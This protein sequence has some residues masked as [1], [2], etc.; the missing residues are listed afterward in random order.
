MPGEDYQSWST[1]A[2]NNGNADSA[3]NWLEGQPRASVNNSSRSQMAAHAKNRNLLNGSIVTTGSPNAQ[4]F[5]SGVAYTAMPP[6]LVAKL[7]IGPSL[8]NTGSAT[9]NMDGLGDILIK[10]DQG[11][12]LAGNELIAGGYT[13]FLYNGTNW[14]LLYSY[15]F[16]FNMVTGGGGLIVGTQVF[17]TPGS[18]VYTPTPTMECC[19]IE[20]IGGGGAGGGTNGDSN[21]FSSGGGGGSGGYSRATATASAIGSSQVVTVGAGGT[22]ALASA[23][24]GGGTT[25]V[26][27]LCIAYGGGGG[28][29]YSY[30]GA[31]ASVGVGDI[32]AGGAYGN[33]GAA[34][35]NNNISGLGA[36]GMSGGAGP[37]GGGGAAAQANG[38]QAYHGLSAS[39]Y[40]SGGGG[41]NSNAAAVQTQGGDGSGGL[42][43]ITEFS[44]RGAPGRD[45][46]PG[47]TGP[48]GPAG[49]GTGDVLHSGTPVAGQLAQW[50]D[51]SHIQG[52]DVGSI[53]FTTGDVKLTF[54]TIA[55]TGWVLMDDGTIGSATSGGTTRANADCQNLF[56]LLW[57]NVN[58]T[59]CPVSGG[60]GATAAA[61]WTANKTIKLPL[62]LGRALA[63]YGTGAG[64]SARV[65]GQNLGAE[66]HVQTASEMPVHAHTVNDPSH[67]HGTTYNYLQYG[68]IGSV[69][70]TT[71]GPNGPY[72]LAI[73]AGY[74]T[75]IVAAYTGIS[76]QNAGGG[77]AM[78]LMQPTLFLNV[79]IKL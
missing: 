11:K 61:D 68:G 50:T 26:G 45:G 51:T 58:N 44:G 41:G 1:T 75:A 59:Y 29:P 40:G 28:Y 3:I 15:Q 42:V 60:R 39:A 57:N 31:G 52:I 33:A 6:M 78:T 24:G 79:M 38:G 13:D 49:P 63:R 21:S 7:K 70:D 71:G 2:I 27:A 77:A 76:L 48:A 8:T 32:A 69:I 18:F 20:C 55:D 4:A 5:L 53:T 62:A 56:T 47:P 12:N 36:W 17:N 72:N 9:L 14:V 43:I 67:T 19:T 74:S 16:F 30:G 35:A 22:G 37:F 25:S 66:T 10:T 64:L 46:P 23:G 34:I 65:L 73:F 54:K